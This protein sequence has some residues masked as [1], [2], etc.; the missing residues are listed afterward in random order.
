MGNEALYLE[1]I[2][3]TLWMSEVTARLQV[4]HSRIN[5]CCK[6]RTQGEGPGRL[7]PSLPSLPCL[8]RLR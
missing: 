6:G 1:V 2:T 4:T 8:L 7:T 5:W 3:E